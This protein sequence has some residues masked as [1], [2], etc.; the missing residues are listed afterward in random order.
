MKTLKETLTTVLLLLM[1]CSY[2]FSQ[3]NTIDRHKLR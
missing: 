1:I 2:S 3:F